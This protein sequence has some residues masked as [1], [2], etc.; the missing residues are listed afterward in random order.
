MLKAN[1]NTLIITG[2]ITL[3][4]MLVGIIYWNRLPD[5]MATHFGMDNTADGYSSKVFAVFGLPA[6]LIGLQW[7]CAFLTAHDPRKKNISPKMFAL[8]L[9]IVPFTSLICAAVMY[10]YNLGIIPDISFYMPLFVGL[11]FIVTGNFLPKARQNYTIGIR[12]AWT[13]ANEENWNR[14]HRFGGHLWVAGGILLIFL[15]LL[16]VRSTWLLLAVVFAVSLI[17]IIYSFYLH[18]KRGL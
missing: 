5:T 11:L 1:K 17:P 15:T 4:P 8:V 10:P 13:L 9:W 2:I 16:G 18:V 12:T 3:L 14:T 7:L 6:L